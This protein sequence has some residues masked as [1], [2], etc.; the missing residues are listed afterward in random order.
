ML[1]EKMGIVDQERFIILANC[2][3]EASRAEAARE[4]IISVLPEK[5]E[6]IPL[7]VKKRS[8]V[9]WLRPDEV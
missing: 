8:R 2:L 6:G 4:R 7:R 3:R 5:E 9:S 1:E